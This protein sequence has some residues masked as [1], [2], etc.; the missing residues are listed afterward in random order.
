MES[1]LK[2]TIRNIK[3]FPK[4]GI[5][6]RDITTLLNNPEALKKTSDAL[7]A[8]SESHRIDKVAGIES[9]GFIFGSILAQKLNAGLVLIRKPGKLPGETLSQDYELEYGIDTLEM[10]KDAIKPGERILLHDDL[11]ATGGSA[12]AACNLIEQAGGII[13][14]ISFIVELSFLNGRD[15]IINYPVESLVTYDSE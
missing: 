9:R 14:Q 3:N 6:F 1:Y 13:V 8:L 11:L 7:I 12:R 2:S 15:K 4:E 5:V 10:H